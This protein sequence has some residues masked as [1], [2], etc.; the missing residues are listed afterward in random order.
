MGKNYFIYGNQTLELQEKS[1][2]IIQTILPE[3]Q[4]NEY[5]VFRFDITDFYSKEKE[6]NEGL[7]TELRNTC[8]TV[9]WLSPQVVV[10]LNNIQA[11]PTRK[12]PIAPVEKSLENITISKLKSESEDIWVVADNNE[13]RSSVSYQTT[14]RQLV[15]DITP[16][17]PN[18]FYLRLEKRWANIE[19]RLGQDNADETTPIKEFLSERLSGNLVFEKPAGDQEYDEPSAEKLVT[20]LKGAISTPQKDVS[21]IFTANVQN[22]RTLNKE[23]LGLL[24][25]HTE[26]IKTTISYDD[27][28]PV[29]WIIDR[30]AKKGLRLNS[31]LADLM[32]EICGSDLSV[33][34][35]EME[36]LSIQFAPETRITASDLIDNVSYS[37]KFSIFR[38]ADFLV[39]KDIKNALE[40]ME[41]ILRDHPSDSIVVFGVI[42][43]QF[44]RLLKVSWMLESGTPEAMII[45]N[46]KLNQWIGKQ[47]VQHCRRYTCRELEN[48]VVYLSK[49]DLPVKYHSKEAM[50]ILEQICY[51]ICLRPLSRQTPI[52]RTWVPVA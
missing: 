39:R 40:S 30:A 37:K 50:M 19:I 8:E 45:K 4:I 21:L 14:A 1:E 43:A 41:A 47:I 12:S 36:K 26:V 11:I 28:R 13:N 49:Q 17:G 6:K 32:I 18:T 20:F 5:S 52:A 38:V 10:V 27:F 2:D 33:L 31:S 9:S 35:G 16:V 25:S 23:I 29:Q 51:Q 3:D 24:E 7:L 22:T 15:S 48:I 42:S 34:D 46:L 44:R